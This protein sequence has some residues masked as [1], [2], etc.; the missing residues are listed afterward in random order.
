MISLRRTK[1]VK[2]ALSQLLLVV[3]RIG[4]AHGVRGEATIEVRTDNPG[5]R[6]EIG[7][8]LHTDPADKGPLT[9]RDAKMHSGT[10]LLSFVGVDDRTAVE[11]LRNVLL[12][13]EIDPTEANVTEDD[14]HLSQ[15]VG[16][17]VIDSSGR[18]WGNVVEV[19]Q[20][21]AQDTLVIKSSDREILI[22]FVRAF[23]PEVNVQERTI[24]VK[25]I[26]GLL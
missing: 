8:V 3:G 26:E 5:E 2:R 4:R 16:C 13:A 7:A 15:I 14:F 1:R 11:K 18:N 22:P 19:L 21:P 10:L 6:F 25:N 12:L 23:V 17:S 9:I 20:L 24:T